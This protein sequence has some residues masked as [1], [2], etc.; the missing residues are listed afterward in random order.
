MTP[1]RRIVKRSSARTSFFAPQCWQRMY[2]RR[3]SSRRWKNLGRSKE[4]RAPQALDGGVADQLGTSRASR[5]LRDSD[6]VRRAQPGAAPR[7]GAI[8]GAPGGAPSSGPRRE[9]RREQQRPAPTT[10]RRAAAYWSGPRHETGDELASVLSLGEPPAVNEAYDAWETGLVLELLG[11]AAG[12]ARGSM[13]ARASAASRSGSRPSSAA[14]RASISPPACWSGSARTRP[15]RESDERRS[16]PLAIGLAS[17]RERLVRRRRSVWG[18]SSTCPAAARAPR[19]RRSRACSARAGLFGLVLNNSGEPA[20]SATRRTTPTA[21][22]SSGRAATTA[23][24][25][26]SR[27]SSR[28]PRPCLGSRSWAR[29]SSIRSSATPRASCP[30]RTGATRSSAPFFERAARVGSWRSVRSGSS[31]APP[32]ITISICSMRR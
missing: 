15:A 5:F 18:F 2:E 21:T 20:S 17:V 29:T 16:A 14:W 23:R 25:S 12:R 11:E 30:T 13:S 7:T 31:R 32:P 9:P 22:G 28:R 6:S 1:T 8:V 10:P 4:L 3:G 27:H 26:P 19:S 24:S